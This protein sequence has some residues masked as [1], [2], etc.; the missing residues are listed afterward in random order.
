MDQKVMIIGYGSTGKYVLDM[1]VRLP[2][3]TGCEYIVVSRTPETEAEKRINLTLVS[4]GIFGNYPKVRYRAC[5]INDVEQLS[6]LIG[7]ETPDVIAYTGRYMKGFKYGEFS[8]PNQIGYGVWTPLAVV[9]VEKLMRAVKMSGINTRVINTSYGDAV[10][11]LLASHGMAPYTSA[12]NLNH[13]IPRIARAYEK[14]SGTPASQCRV[15]FAGSHYANTYIS[16]EGTAKGSPC[17]LHIEGNEGI[18][19]EEI[20]RLCAI[21]TASGPDRN[22]M[23]ASDVVMLIR[24]MLDQSGEERKIHAPGPFGKIGGYPLLFKNGQMKIDETHFTMEEM[25]RVN[26]GSL[27]CDGIDALDENGIHFTNEVIGKMKTVFAIDYPKTLALEDCERFS[28]KLAETLGGGVY[29]R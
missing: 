18:K 10:S 13:L 15:T 3:L 4:S 19:E 27:R 28:E 26:E 24:L 22:I 9:L 21:P 25:E 16:K 8:Y 11:P 7:Q 5:D 1:L 2:D 29:G 12:G 17:L 20:W 14:L 23:I 6:E